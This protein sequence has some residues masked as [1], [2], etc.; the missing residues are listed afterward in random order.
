MEPATESIQSGGET[1]GDSGNDSLRVFLV[2][3]SW[4][5]RD[6]RQILRFHGRS[7]PASG[8]RPVEILIDH[9]RPVFFIERSAQLPGEGLPPHERAPVEL[10]NFFNAPVDA[11]YFRNEHDLR[12]ARERLPEIGIRTFESDVHPCERFRMERFLSGSIQVTPRENVIAAS[13]PLRL[14]NPRVRPASG[15]EDDVELVV[16]SIDI[17]TGVASGQLYSIAVHTYGGGR[18]PDRRVYMLAG[19]ESRGPTAGTTGAPAVAEIMRSEAGEEFQYIL[20]A[21]ERELLEAFCSAIASELDPDIFIGWNVIGFDLKFL[22]AKAAA[23]GLP[24]RLGRNGR[25]AKVRERAGGAGDFA[26]VPGR[27]VLDGPMVM[28]AAFYN[29]PDFRLESVARSLLGRGKL[30]HESEA[31]Q[32]IAEIDRQFR[33]D[34]PQLARYNLE[35]CE[36]VSE[37]FQHAGLIDLWKRRSQISGMLLDQIGRSVAA[38]D[39]FLLPRL[40]RKGY[41]AISEQDVLFEA[42]APGG[43]VMEPKSGLHHDVIVLDFR[44]LYPSI[45]RT[46]RID[47]YS[48]LMQQLAEQEDEENPDANPIEV[49]GGQLHFSRTEHI[50]PDFI[51][52]LLEQRARAKQIGDS[53]LSTAIKILMNSFYGVMGSPGCRFYHSDLPSAITRT[54]Q[55]LLLE[56]RAH[57]ESLGYEV[58]YGDTDSLFV[59]VAENS[60]DG[61]V[62]QIGGQLARK[63]NEYWTDRIRNEFDLHSYMEMEYEKHFRKFLLP[64]ARAGGAAKKRYAGLLVQ[65]DAEEL[66]FVGMETV[67]SDWTDAAKDF[68]RGL[69]ERIFRENAAPV[70]WIKAFVASLREG[71]FDD[72]LVYRK[73]L[74]KPVHEYVKN[75]PQHVRAAR[76]LDKPG[77]SISYLM[78]LQKGPV[79]IQLKPTD[80]D[81]A[82]YLEH[83]LKPIADTV[84]GFFDTNFDEIV[85]ST[86]LNLF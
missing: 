47:P 65:G 21:S 68:Q 58:L 22:V 41:V 4:E 32:K 42:A 34:R 23:L 75:I 86:Q 26:S 77:S 62:A 31:E 24:L 15:D 12:R 78:T 83:Q 10:K 80:I 84:L 79:P 18:A 27:A 9:F 67:R 40:H 46:F 14:L 48:R 52:E 63:L 30:I 50:L 54:G 13:Q 33:E 19:N 61:S 85:H 11:L 43:Y 56:S 73:R 45:I 49:P 25:L 76:M 2:T 71:E 51:G 16:S 36:L 37:I 66:H 60:E 55:W 57:L 69:Y 7:D 28:R 81:Y 17:E 3:D 35:D 5:E 29:F 6:G 72:G 74:R 39:F 20:C 70:D 64:P 44:S 59:S 1:S 53:H 38:F 82:Y 8:N